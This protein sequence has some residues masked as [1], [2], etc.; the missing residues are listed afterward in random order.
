MQEISSFRNQ[1]LIAMPNLKDP[2]FFHSVTFVC[3]HNSEGALG[4]VIN[5]P[6]SMVLGD[7]LEQMDIIVEDEKI[8]KIPVF[9]GGPVQQERGFVLHQT[10]EELWESTIAVSGT[11]S[12]T[13]SRDILKAIALGK[14]PAKFLIALGYAGWGE[15]QLETEMKANAWLSTR[16]DESVV[17]DTPISQRWNVAAHK[18]GLDI[19]L[20][21]TQVGHA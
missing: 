21:S 2:N 14:G 18:M 15:E 5:H 16:Y 12:L 19:N 7:I 9:A 8:A 13:T 1:L 11:L 10:S 17:F 3:Q 4:L 6:T 20:L